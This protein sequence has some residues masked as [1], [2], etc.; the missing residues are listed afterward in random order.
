MQYSLQT[1]EKVGLHLH[2]WTVVDKCPLSF[3]HLALE[4]IALATQRGRR[5]AARKQAGPNEC[6][7]PSPRPSP[8]PHYCRRRPPRLIF[9]DKATTPT[10]VG[11]RTMRPRAAPSEPQ[12]RPRREG[13][14]RKLQGKEGKGRRRC[15]CP[16]PQ[17]QSAFA[18]RR[19]AN[20]QK[21]KSERRLPIYL[22]YIVFLQ[23]PYRIAGGFQGR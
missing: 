13:R 14:Q 2:F 12:I 19:A 9:R 4:Q 10:I 22:F 5:S 8:S 6:P 11:V 1:R 17:P 15:D 23:W 20:V 18:L 16:A 3:L 7:P 21:R